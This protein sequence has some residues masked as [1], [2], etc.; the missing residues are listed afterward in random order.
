METIINNIG[1]FGSILYG[2]S[3]IPQTY[4]IIKE[5]QTKNISLFFL[6]LSMYAALLMTVYGVY[7][8]LVPIIVSNILV[9]INCTIII[10]YKCF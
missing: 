9:L 5:K 10:F 1:L 4:K 3:F 2:W 8:E 6:I 7:Y